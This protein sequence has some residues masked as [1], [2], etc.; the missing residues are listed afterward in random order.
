MSVSGLDF[1]PEISASLPRTG[2]YSLHHT[3]MAS[4]AVAGPSATTPASALALLSNLPISHPSFS[5]L[6][7]AHIPLASSSALPHQALNKLLGRINTAV[8]SRENENERR[9]AWGLAQEVIAQDVEGY[10]LVQYGKAWVTA[11]IG[12]VTVSYSRPAFRVT[13]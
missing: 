6:L 12:A 2:I 1:E 13:S 4:S 11:S 7:Q 10:A 5:S 8:L 9:I 3:N